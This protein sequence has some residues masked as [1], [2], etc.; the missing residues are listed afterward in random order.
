[1]EIDYSLFKDENEKIKEIREEVY[2]KGNNKIAIIIPFVIFLCLILVSYYS[3]DK[4]NKNQSLENKE[5]IL[6]LNK[7]NKT[8]PATETQ[9]S[10]YFWKNWKFDKLA[11]VFD[12]YNFYR[13]YNDYVGTPLN[14]TS[15][16]Q[17]FFKANITLDITDLDNYIKIKNYLGLDNITLEKTIEG[18]IFVLTLIFEEEFFKIKF[19]KEYFIK[20]LQNKNIIRL[21]IAQFILLS[22]I[23]YFGQSNDYSE[24]ISYA[25]DLFYSLVYNNN[26][27]N[28]NTL[29]LK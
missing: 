1:M 20:L 22:T 27:E 11:Y 21:G 17:E 6:F 12:L 15:K 29:L 10:K 7:L 5:T 4:S 19:E 24:I 3:I 2:K 16:I 14:I 8:T 28:N 26:K 18:G 13:I 9:K 23:L 25:K